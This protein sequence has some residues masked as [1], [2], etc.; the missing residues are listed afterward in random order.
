V[1]S[2]AGHGI[3]SQHEWI[4]KPLEIRP[5]KI[6]ITKL[7]VTEMLGEVKTRALHF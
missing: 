6:K 4:L 3:H 2:S 7:L 5:K 1:F